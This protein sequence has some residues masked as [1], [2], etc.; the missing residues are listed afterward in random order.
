MGFWGKL[1]KI[2]LKAAPIAA[3]FIPGVGPLASMAISAGTSG[4][5]KKLE[6]GSWKDSL[7][8]AG[9]GGA[10]GYAGGK[11]PGI[12]PSTGTLAKV[13]DVGAGVLNNVSQS[14]LNSSPNIATGGMRGP[15]MNMNDPNSTASPLFGQNQMEMPMPELDPGIGPSRVPPID[16]SQAVNR[17]PY[18]NNPNIG[19]SIMRGRRLANPALGY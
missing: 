2:A 6:G 16:Y 1:G 15:A 17:S 18:S 10:A 7:L 14:A 13:K 19:N 12:G 4:L 5:S 8:S 3:A 11:I 9:I